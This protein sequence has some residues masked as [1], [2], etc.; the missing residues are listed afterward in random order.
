MRIKLRLKSPQ[1]ADLV[2]L[3]D[4]PQIDLES[5]LKLSLIS[6]VRREPFHIETPLNAPQNISTVKFVGFSLDDDEER[7]IIEWYQGIPEGLKSTALKSIIRSALSRAFVDSFSSVEIPYSASTKKEI[8]KVRDK[9]PVAKEKEKLKEE[10]NDP[11]KIEKPKKENI[12]KDEFSLDD[13]VENY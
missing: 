6:H 12:E 1:D 2:A 9:K 3:K 13:L 4:S 11:P 8:S 7:D 10:K 5:I